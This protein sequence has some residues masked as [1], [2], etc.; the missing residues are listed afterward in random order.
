MR[1]AQQM[2]YAAMLDVHAQ[3]L[4]DH[5]VVAV[6][7]GGRGTEPLDPHP[8]HRGGLRSALSRAPVLGHGVTLP[9]PG[10]RH[11]AERARASRGTP[12]MGSGRHGA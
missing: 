3:G 2:A 8:S 5:D 12:M 6:P 1:R 7:A 11:S 9:A 10:S 4:L